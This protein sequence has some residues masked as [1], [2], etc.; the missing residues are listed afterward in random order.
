[1]WS[2]ELSQS[3]RST[4]DHPTSFSP[5]RPVHSLL[6]RSD[7]QTAAAAIVGNEMKKVHFV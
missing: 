3:A 4:V 7:E 1:M 5:R 2:G 6:T